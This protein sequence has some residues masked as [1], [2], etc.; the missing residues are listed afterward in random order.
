M[1]LLAITGRLMASGRLS[2]I[3]LVSNPDQ[4]GQP[5]DTSTFRE[6]QAMAIKT[7][8]DV[9]KYAKAHPLWRRALILVKSV[10]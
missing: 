2:G 5:E 6:D 3:I 7:A 10:S 8:S 4:V 9:T 1:P